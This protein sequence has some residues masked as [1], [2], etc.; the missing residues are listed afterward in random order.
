[1]GYCLADTGQEGH[2]DTFLLTGHTYGFCIREGTTISK[3]Y[4]KDI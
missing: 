3:Y 4:Q 1:M 2:K